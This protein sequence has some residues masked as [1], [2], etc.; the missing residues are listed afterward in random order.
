MPNGILIMYNG[1]NA[2]DP[3]CPD[4]TWLLGPALLVALSVGYAEAQTNSDVAKETESASSH[5]ANS[6]LA[7][8]VG[9]KRVARLLTW[10]DKPIHLVGYSYYG[11][12]GDRHFDAENFLKIL[13]AHNINF[14]RF[15]LILPWPVEPGPNLLPFAKTGDKYDLRKYDDQF[16]VRLSAIVK[17][18]DELGIVCQ[19]CLFDRCGLAVNDRN[20]WANNPYN[21]AINVNGLLARSSGGYPPFCQTSGPIA[22]INAAFIRQVVETI[23]DRGNVIYEIMNEPFQQLGPLQQ[24]HVWAAR[25]LR[26]NLQGRCGSQVIASTYLFDVDE[27]D[28]FSMHMAGDER[29]VAEAIRQSKSVKKPVILSDDGDMRSMFNPD[30]TRVAA[31]RALELGQHFEHL[32]FTIAQQR[33]QER[34]PAD[35]LD[36]LPGLCRLNLQTLATLTTPLGRRRSLP[37]VPRRKPDSS[38]SVELGDKIVESGMFRVRPYMADGVLR[39]TQRAGQPCY[40]TDERRRGKYAYFRLADSFPRGDVPQMVTITVEYHDDGAGAKLI[41][42][43]DAAGGAYTAAAP[44]SLGESGQWKS[45]TFKLDDATFRGRQNDGADFRFSLPVGSHALALRSVRLERPG[46]R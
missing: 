30:V 26:K 11:L 29:R 21:G 9:L 28:V 23:G 44:V 34:R 5:V 32:E 24:W 18:A 4:R 37:P 6:E 1:L 19:V 17:R 38:W 45:A 22:Q 14:T 35:S 20:A 2:G 3:P 31:E 15:F 39:R 41:L 12:L 25:E 43:Y 40:E 16:F 46:G 42:E 27:I 8:A 7:N 10:G 13:A 33:E 36:Q